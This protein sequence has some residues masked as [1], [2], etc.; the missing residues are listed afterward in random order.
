M[1]LCRLRSG[2]FKVS[3]KDHMSVSIASKISRNVLEIGSDGRGSVDAIHGIMLAL[4]LHVKLFIS[5][6]LILYKQL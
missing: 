4:V 5:I 6:K 3:E 1:S 2:S